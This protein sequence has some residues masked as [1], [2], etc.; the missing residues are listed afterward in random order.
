MCR[1]QGFVKFCEFETSA[2]RFKLV[3]IALS[4]AD[5]HR[6]VFRLVN[7][8]TL[9]ETNCRRS[10]RSFPRMPRTTGLNHDSLDTQW[11]ARL[12]R[13]VVD[14]RRLLA[15]SFFASRTGA[16]TADL[17]IGSRVLAQ[18]SREI[19]N[20][21]SLFRFPGAGKGGLVDRRTALP[22]TRCRLRAIHCNSWCYGI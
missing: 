10:V 6:D 11:T 19:P 8:Y 14:K 17:L 18:A 2:A 13:I 3:S 12:R 16:Y 9:K 5:A 22:L 20:V 4:A 15:P 21:V 7:A 1:L